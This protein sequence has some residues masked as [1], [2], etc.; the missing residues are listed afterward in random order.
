MIEVK[1]LSM[2]FPQLKDW[3]FILL[4]QSKK[5]PIGEMKGWNQDRENKTFSSDSPKLLEHIMNKGNYG[6]VT[7]EDR[8]VLASDT[9]DVENA[10]SSRLPKTFSVRSPRHKTKHFYFYGEVKSNI[11]FKSTSAGDPCCDLKHG[12]AYVLGPDSEFENYGK[13]EVVDDLPI[14]TITQEQILSALDEL[15]KTIS[16]DEIEPNNVHEQYI[17]VRRPSNRFR[18]L[19]SRLV[20]L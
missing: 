11:Q 4:L 8:L 6:V 20:L 16:L 2:I 12:N 18:F 1:A 14:A 15:I 13:Y 7:G 9:V 19:R 10:I 17:V 3:R 5:E